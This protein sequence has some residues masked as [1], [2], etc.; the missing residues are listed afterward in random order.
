[1]LFAVRYRVPR[2]SK[3]LRLALNLF[4]KGDV[5]A[6]YDEILRLRQSKFHLSPLDAIFFSDVLDANGQVRRSQAVLRLAAR[7]YPD[8]IYILV[9]WTMIRSRQSSLL[10]L[11]QSLEQ[12]LPRVVKKAERLWV[13]AALAVLYA[14]IGFQSKAH[15]TITRIATKASKRLPI[16]WFRLSMASAALRNWEEACRYGKLALKYAP[17]WMD[18]RRILVSHL[19]ASGRQDEAVRILEEGAQLSIQDAEYEY[20]R[21]QFAYFIG[22]TERSIALME[23][24]LGR[25]SFDGSRNPYRTLVFLHCLAGNYY[26]AQELASLHMPEFL[27]TLK[28]CDPNALRQVVQVPIFCQEHLMCVPTS[29]AICAGAQGVRLDSRELF[30]AMK[31][32]HGTELWRMCNEMAARG[33]H[34]LYV[35]SSWEAIT[36]FLRQGIPLIGQTD[37]LFSSHVEVVIGFDTSLQA[38]VIRDPESLAPSL[39]SA[40]AMMD[41]YQPTGSFLLALVVPERQ[42]AISIDDAWL[43]ADGE[44][45]IRLAKAVSLADL[46]STEEAFF[47][48]PD[49]SPCAY[50]RDVYGYGVTLTP[51]QFAGRMRNYAIDEAQHPLIRLKALLHESDAEILQQWIDRRHS[52]DPP[53]GPFVMDYLQLILSF[54]KGQWESGLTLVKR[55]IARSPGTDQLWVRK[56]EIEIELGALEAARTSASTA[57]DLSPRSFWIKSRLRQLYPYAIAYSDQ[58]NELDHQLHLTPG[59]FDVIAQRAD[60]L[61]DGP[62]GLRYEAA[63]RACIARSPLLPAGYLKL[64]HWFQ[65]QGRTELACAILATGRTRIPLAEIPQQS[66]EPEVAELPD[67]KAN[68]L[69]PSLPDQGSEETELEPTAR[70]RLAL[71]RLSWEW[72]N[73]VSLDPDSII[74]IEQHLQSAPAEQKSLS[75][76]EE[77]EA[78]ALR[79]AAA[80]QRQASDRSNMKPLQDYLPAS[81]PG[82]THFAVLHFNRTIGTTLSPAVCQKLLSW[83]QGLLKGTDW[84][85]D[86]EFDLAYLQERSGYLNAAWERY[87]EI[88]ARAPG[89]ASAWYRSA[90]ILD[91][92]GHLHDAV[93]AL[94]TA[95]SITP[96]LPGAIERLIQYY[97]SVGDGLSCVQWAKRYL[98]LFPYQYFAIEKTIEWVQRHDGC[99]GAIA[100]LEEV[101]NRVPD[102]IYKLLKARVLGENHRFE[103]ALQLLTGI[104]PVAGFERHELVTRLDCALG[105]QQHAQALELIEIGL[106]RNP[107]DDWFITCKATLLEEVDAQQAL[108]FYESMFEQNIIQPQCVNNWVRHT[109]EN[110]PRS[111]HAWL[112]RLSI[113]EREVLA[114]VLSRVYAYQRLTDARIAHLEYCAEQLPHLHELRQDLA[115][116]YNSK[117]WDEKAIIVAEALFDEYP[118]LPQIHL[119]LGRILSDKYP[120]RALRHLEKEYEISGSVDAL[121]HIGRIQHILGEH[122]KARGSYHKV[123]KLNPH[124]DLAINNLL[125]LH[126]DPAILF[127][128]FVGAL[129]SGWGEDSEYFH[130][131][132]VFCAVLTRRV[133][134]EVWARG[135]EARFERLFVVKPFRDERERLA[136]ALA[137]WHRKKGDQEKAAQYLKRAGMRSSLF[138]RWRWPGSRWVPASAKAA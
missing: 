114:T 123:L 108:A 30:K 118:D 38:Y 105:L 80:V 63:M 2:V 51:G 3:P 27:D 122:H 13:E 21:S 128:H 17:K 106:E 136:L 75:W 58:L 73:G 34:I 79:F 14:R 71:Q 46:P 7:T 116:C 4:K 102:A 11:S 54:M 47:N 20:F 104:D 81:L 43:S 127:P 35:K 57:V 67:E 62:D 37:N 90:C 112:D 120:Q 40:K 92:K 85:P 31:G 41:Q 77:V 9:M 78:Y 86:L 68:D 107:R 134:P 59:V 28:G 18:A 36:G 98:A 16:I 19:L 135:A 137:Q 44:N 24:T 26:R 126:E 22:D 82:Q 69:S 132:A 117:G 23:A 110:Q 111:A 6:A 42:T 109:C 66:Y 72:Q 94:T 83:Q 5:Q 32:N 115:F 1:M 96:M 8:D 52:D 138:M 56:A 10:E 48:I 76:W 125:I 89:Y 50:Q 133:L 25:W 130:V 64:A 45:L 29:V 119:L 74:C 113:E 91:Q 55:M 49:D 101:R 39:V 53:F 88:C 124:Y 99:E 33:F 103:Q 12:L 65:T 70:L 121:A 93:P 131:N 95:V 15:D 97:N 129:Q 61:R 60:L 100:I 87:Q 84:L